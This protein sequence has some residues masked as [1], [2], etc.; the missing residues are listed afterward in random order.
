VKKFNRIL[1]IALCFGAITNAWALWPASADTSLVICDRTGQEDLGKVAVTSDGGC[2]IS[3]Y[4]WA[5]G[6]WD[7]YLQR[8]DSLGVPQWQVGGILIDGH[9]QESWVTDYD[10]AVDNTD[11]AIVSMN[12]TRTG[13]DRDIYAYRISPE[14]NFLWGA[15]G[16]TLSNNND[17]E[18]GPRIA[19]TSGGNIVFAWQQ[20]TTVMGNVVNVR[21]VTPAGTDVWAPATITLTSQYGMSIPRIVAAD[22]DQ[23]IV[24]Y[25][26]ARGSGMYAAKHIFVQKF[27]SV[28]APMWTDTGRVVSSNGGIGI[29]MFPDLIPDGHGGA[30]SFWYD[31]H[32]QNQLHVFAQHVS[33]GGTMTWQAGGLQASTS[34]TE[35]QSSPSAACFPGTDHLAVFYQTANSGQTQYGFGGQ[36]ISADGQ[37]R[38]G[39]A[40]IAFVPVGN[41]SSDFITARTQ[42][43]GVTVAY[44]AGITGTTY[45]IKAMHVD[46]AGSMIWNNSP[47]TLCSNTATKG[48]LFASVNRFGQFLATWT[49]QRHDEG[50]IY[51]QNINADG[52]LG[53]LAPPV[54]PP[55]LNITAPADS[56]EAIVLPVLVTFE[57]ENFVIARS[58]GDGVL[59]VR[60][61]G[62]HVEWHD[63]VGAIRLASL[64]N[65]LNSVVLE[66]VTYAHQSLD[67]AV[68]DS[69]RIR[70]TPNDAG[71]LN[72]DL[73]TVFS[74]LPAYPNPFNPSTVLT[75]TLPQAAVVR[76]SIFNVLG[77][78]VAKLV[79]GMENAGV[80]Q[81]SFDGAS[82]SG[83][84]YFCRIEAGSLTRMQK[85]VLLK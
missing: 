60:V 29:Q 71:N 2:Y 62:T 79:N 26:I 10:L 83:G 17:F 57:T 23:V 41:Q 59:D 48:R 38:W 7:I 67:P 51:L 47:R 39:G 50:D 82:L 15:D 13:G 9:P 16:L 1:L 61:N 56:S 19:V 20:E 33:T 22:S 31:S 49:D 54:L 27:D 69:V 70:Y 76:L 55:V 5:S 81:I 18:A 84:I 75:Y 46:S 44:R 30:F 42:D 77:Q 28:G 74:L 37:R 8:L 21:K 40:G 11:N 34:N 12:D 32:L 4:D 43:T 6:N 65:G 45:L 64:Q 85:L 25:L 78:E 80:H 66:L 72:P 36:L 58:G 63:S 52:S 24:Q 14:G 68:I 73:P 3:W 53:D 35:I